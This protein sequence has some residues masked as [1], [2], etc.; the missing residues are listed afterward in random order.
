M[1]EHPD[2]HLDELVLEAEAPDRLR[3]DEH[4]QASS[5]WDAWD[6]APPDATDAA[7]LRRAPSGAAAEKL[8][9]PAPG[10]LER[11]AWSQPAH[12]SAQWE[13]RFV[14]AE[15]CTPGAAQSEE[16][17]CGARAVV[18]GP[19]RLALLDAVVPVEP[20]ARRMQ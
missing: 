10:D 2:E 16:R 11:D 5:A 19:L 8:A 7:D 6:D 1:P 15:L 12:L 14:V 9:V 18:A 4:P 13:P 17:S 20:E 3:E